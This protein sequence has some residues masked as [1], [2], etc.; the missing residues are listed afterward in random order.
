MP[1]A[2]LEPFVTRLID[3]PID[4]VWRVFAEREAAHAG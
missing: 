1:E 4:V 2:D 3:A